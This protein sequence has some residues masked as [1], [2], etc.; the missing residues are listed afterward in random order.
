MKFEILFLL[1]FDWGFQYCE[2]LRQEFLES[3]VAGKTFLASQK[4]RL[5]F[6]I[7]QGFQDFS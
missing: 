4:D 6:K 1:R 2:I 7:L 3:Y 5:L